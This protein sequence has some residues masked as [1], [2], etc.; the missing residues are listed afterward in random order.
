MGT[1]TDRCTPERPTVHWNDYL[2][3]TLDA[4]RA[5]PPAPLYALAHSL[6]T[7]CQK[8]R[9]VYT[10]GNGGSASAASHL[11]QDLG[12][13]T[14]VERAPRLRC[15]CLCDSIPNITAWANDTEYANVFSWQMGALG[16]PGDLLIAI[17]GS[18]NSENVLRAVREAHDLEMHT[19]GVTG[20]D[21]GALIGLAHRCVH[22]PVGDMGMAEAAHGVLFHWLI[23][24]L[25]EAFESVRQGK[26]TILDAWRPPEEVR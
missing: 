15:I 14:I 26:S 18:G 4:L 24:Y 22:V 7:A 2:R 3:T 17:S 9:T 19:W 10:C 12:K 25:R 13:G 8:G 1:A 23:T 11:A 20:F 16:Q 21:G 5:T 6:F